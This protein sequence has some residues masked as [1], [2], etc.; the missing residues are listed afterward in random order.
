MAAAGLW[1]T[2][3]DL[4]RFAIEVQQSRAGKSTKVLSQSLTRQQLTVERADYGL[5]LAITGSGE[6]RTFGHNGRDAGFD[7]LLLAFEEAGQGVV[8]MIN[9][10][11]NSGMM[12]RIVEFVGR[13]HNWPKRSSNAPAATTAVAP[14]IELDAVTG[15]YE[16]SNNNMLTLVSRGDSL[17]SDV[18]GLPDEEFLFVGDDRFGSRDRNI[19]FRISRNAGGEVVGLTWSDGARERPV[20]RIGGLFA[21][22]TKVADPD[23]CSRKASPQRCA[24][25][26][27]VARL[28][29]ACS[30]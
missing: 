1:T 18:N 30:N 22:I 3:T 14:A 17:F 5:G 12:R 19:S 28:S 20:P 6:A 26:P 16:L 25:W 24:R 7:A 2:A 15:R 29:A 13:T 8:I 10:N 21:S 23:R 11:D 27:R 4:A 9:A